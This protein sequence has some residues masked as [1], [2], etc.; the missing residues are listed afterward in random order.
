MRDAAVSTSP[1]EP[2]KA[3]AA[4]A[5]QRARETEELFRRL[6][7]D[8]DAS[9]REQLAE[10]FLPL[11]RQLARR[12]QRANEPLD[13]LV[14]V[15]SMG[16]VKAIDRFDLDR[17]VAFSSYAVPTI[18][19]ELKR[20]FRD[21][22]WA[23]HVPR[24]VQERA[25]QVDRTVKELSGK[26][27]RSPSVDEVAEAIGASQE[28]VLQAME[29]GQAYEAVS[30]D[31]QRAAGDGEGN[32][33]ADSLGEEDE[34]F[35]LVEYGATIAPTLKALPKRDQLVLH[36]RFAEDMTQS[37]IAERIGVSQMQVSRLIRRA[38]ARLRTVADA[39]EKDRLDP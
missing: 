21:A 6:R 15:A 24:G 26:L 12:Y 27:G 28:D 5:A 25:M 13:D 29:A 1:K 37:Q 17:G 31:A 4:D 32:T 3:Q 36:L 16:L 34:R 22:G 20:Y 2:E 14:Q 38:L 8:D 30:L 10:R 39:T 23:V 35:E 33:F 9:A 11:A 18:L 7:Q 19:G